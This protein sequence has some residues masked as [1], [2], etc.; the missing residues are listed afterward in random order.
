MT[1]QTLH[2]KFIDE[3]F[4]Y[5]GNLIDYKL[6]CPEKFNFAYDVIDKIAELEPDR[7]AIIWCNPKGEKQ[8]FTYGDLKKNSDKVANMLRAK[9]IGKG[10]KVMLVLKRHYQFWFTIYA[11]HKL[12]AIAIPAT[13][14][15]TKHDVEYRA[16]AAG[17]K[18]IICTGDGDV[19]EHVDTAMPDCPT[20][21]SRIMVNGSRDGWDSFA[22]L[23]EQA[24]DKFEPIDYTSHDPMLMYFSSGTTGNP[25][26]VLHQNSYPIGHLITAKYWHN[27]NPNGLHLTISD[28]GWAKAAWG[29]IY[30]QFMMGS[31]QFIY[32]FDKFDAKDILEKISDYKITTLCCPPTMFR[33][34]LQ[35]DVKSYDLSSLSYCNIAGE[36]LSPDVFNK[37]YEAT[38]I[39]LME[40]FGQ[41]ETTVLIANLIGMTPKPGSM[42]KPVPHY[43]V[44]IVD[45]NGVPVQTGTTGEIVVRTEFKAPIGLFTEYYNDDVKTKESWHDGFYHTGDT[46]WCDEDGYF[47]YVG[48]TDDVIKSSGY[49]IGPFEIESV[50][51]EHPSVLESAV[52]G[53][54]DPIRG[55]LVKATIVLRSGFEPSDDLIKEIQTFV[56]NETAPY[57]YPRIV[58]FV[59]ELPKTTSGKIRRIAI[60][61]ADLEKNNN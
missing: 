30:G 53:I 11:L 52:T 7:M 32:D 9:G 10:D 8:N 46:A 50:L 54:P 26:M 25:K 60:R 55:N 34:F 44:K 16:N 61:Q 21:K 31:C 56:K 57:K 29:K 28:T 38:G 43:D 36:A 3:T 4:D 59:D 13:F 14:L 23:F 58:E 45:E 42:G 18:M 37:W 1:A 39:K 51:A 15:L 20:V 22:Q 41:T 6:I 12:G 19:A 17:V 33:F 48:R 27:V 5:S 24:S 47:W 40:G 2:K 35:E 49:R